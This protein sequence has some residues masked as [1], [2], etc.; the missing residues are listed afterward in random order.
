MYR[1]KQAKGIAPKLVAYSF[2]IPVSETV[3]LK[4]TCTGAESRLPGSTVIGWISAVPCFFLDNI[5]LFI[6][7]NLRQKKCF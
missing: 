2:A 1:W 6:K 7:A 5:G 4:T 3:A